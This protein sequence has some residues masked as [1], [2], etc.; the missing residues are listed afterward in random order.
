MQPRSTPPKK[1]EGGLG[2]PVRRAKEDPR[3]VRL[4]LTG[5]ALAIVGLLVVVP[6]AN[7]FVG[8]L[9]EG[10]GVYWKNLVADALSASGA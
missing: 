2:A 7:V 5:L 10:V 4:T 3:W 6:I 1:P 8:A 9:S